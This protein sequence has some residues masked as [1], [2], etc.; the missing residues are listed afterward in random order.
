MTTCRMSA[1]RVIGHALWIGSLLTLLAIIAV[2]VWLDSTTGGYG[3]TSVLLTIR[4]YGITRLPT[5]AALSVLIGA[6][7]AAAMHWSW[8]CSTRWSS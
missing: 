8:C 6:L 2:S 3:L 7:T 4:L 5:S 1:L